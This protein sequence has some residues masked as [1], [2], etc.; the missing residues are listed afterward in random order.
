MRGCGCFHW[1]GKLEEK[2]LR[3]KWQQR[4]DHPTIIQPRETLDD[5]CGASTVS[6]KRRRKKQLSRNCDDTRSVLE[7][8]EPVLVCS[9]TDL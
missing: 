7:G 4:Q 2:A 5:F 3:S 8:V 6:F 1:D 9:K